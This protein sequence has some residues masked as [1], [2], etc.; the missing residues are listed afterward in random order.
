MTT[1]A[2]SSLLTLQK[3]QLSPC[4][5]NLIFHEQAFMMVLAV[6]ETSFTVL[7]EF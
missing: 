1:E 5:H 3:P 7:G 6:C 2:R 4:L